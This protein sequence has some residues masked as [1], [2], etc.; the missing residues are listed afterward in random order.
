MSYLDR[1]N[2][3]KHTVTGHIAGAALYGG[4]SFGLGYVK[5]R[6]RER[7]H[8][9]GVPVDLLTAI[10]FKGAAVASVLTGKGASYAPL[11]DAFG[12]AGVS[13]FFHTLGA[14]YG[15]QHSG[16]RRMLIPANE[17]E[18]AKRSFPNATVLGEI[19]KAPP[20]DYLSAGDLM[21]MARG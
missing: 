12:N 21:R 19:E 10:L 14:A 4:A 11:A 16:L 17:V 20:G 5:N 13:S 3:T 2:P 15:A 7:A 18:R 6:W 8:V 1:L 9:F